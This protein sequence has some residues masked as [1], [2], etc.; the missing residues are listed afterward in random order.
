MADVEVP[1][2][3][4]GLLNGIAQKMFFNNDEM[5]E[6]LLKSELF[7]ELPQEEFKA[8]HEKMRGLIKVRKHLKW[9]KKQ[10]IFL[11]KLNASSGLDRNYISYANKTKRKGKISSVKEAVNSD[12]R[13]RSV[14]K[15]DLHEKRHKW[16]ETSYILGKRI[17][18][19]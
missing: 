2:S 1:K 13:S 15:L 11:P 8:L 5:T 9:K 19:N 3:L 12:R 17:N 6:E 14:K 4:S 16:P 10:T 18:A 7:P